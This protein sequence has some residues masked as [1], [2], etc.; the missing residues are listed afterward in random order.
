MR[1]AITG[2]IGRY[3]QL[4]RYLDRDAIDSIATYHSQAEVRLAAVELINRE[5]TEIVRDASRRLFE[6]DPELL[7]P[8]GNAYTTRRLSA[9]LRDMDYF[10]RYASYALV[11]GDPTILNERVLNGLDDTYKSLGVPTGP[12]VRSIVLLGEVLAERLSEAGLEP[13]NLI[14]APFEHMARGLADTNLR[15]S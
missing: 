12:T 10:L 15:A 8:G 14:N 5:A 1:D 3:D 9:C 2:L 4:G 13:G 11:A 7:L 6:Q